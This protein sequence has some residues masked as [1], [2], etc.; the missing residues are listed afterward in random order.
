[1]ISLSEQTAAEGDREREK[2]M[3]GGNEKGETKWKGGKAV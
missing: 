3:R 2:K 1:M